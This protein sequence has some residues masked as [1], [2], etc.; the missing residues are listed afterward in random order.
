MSARGW[1]IGPW[2]AEKPMSPTKP[3]YVRGAAD[4]KIATIDLQFP[5]SVEEANARLIASAPELYEALERLIEY[6]ALGMWSK[7][8]AAVESARATLA[9]A[10]GD[11]D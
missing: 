2:F 8:V 7:Y 1:S 4:R 10:R 9:R 11:S 3:W 5:G 6:S